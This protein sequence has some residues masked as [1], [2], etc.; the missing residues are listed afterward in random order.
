[1]N[2]QPGRRAEDN[3]VERMKVEARSALVPI[4]I[5]VLG[6][7]LWQQISK[8]ERAVQGVSD[9]QRQ[10]AVLVAESQ[11]SNDTIK[12]LKLDVKDTSS[13][14]KAVIST[15]REHERRLNGLEHRDS[16]R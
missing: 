2:D 9:N 13:N 15:L 12:Q 7:F 16:R 4:F 1:M 3:R 6:F 11:Y 5:S 10:L 14:Y 8:I